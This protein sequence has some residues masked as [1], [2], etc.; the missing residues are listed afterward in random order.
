MFI[1]ASFIAVLYGAN[2][3]NFPLG[4]LPSVGTEGLEKVGNHAQMH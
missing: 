3:Y 2:N 1:A 4:W